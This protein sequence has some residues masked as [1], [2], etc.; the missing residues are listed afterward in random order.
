MIA[1]IRTLATPTDIIDPERTAA[2]FDKVYVEAGQG[3]R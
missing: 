3:H 1:A 2:A